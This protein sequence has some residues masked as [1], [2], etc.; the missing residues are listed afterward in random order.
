MKVNVLGREYE[1]VIGEEKD[2]PHLKE[3]N[4][5]CDFTIGRIVVEKMEVEEDTWQD[6]VFYTNK[7]IRHE[8]VHAFLHESGLAVNS[9]WAYNEEL[10][11]W[12]AIQLPKM[13]EVFEEIEV[14]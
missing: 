1:I 7:V 6:M 5:Y 14:M 2:Y 9:D 4:G 12:I 11:D 3:A 8:L 10:V 13:A